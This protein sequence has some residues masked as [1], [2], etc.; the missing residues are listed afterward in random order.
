MLG[1][2]SEGVFYVSA[3]AQ[4]KDL[5]ARMWKQVM[6]RL[7]LGSAHDENQIGFGAHRACHLHRAMHRNVE[8]TL[9]QQCGDVFRGWLTH[10]GGNTGG[11]HDDAGQPAA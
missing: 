10:R 9:R 4:K 2:L 8:A 11:A 6:S 7:H 3:F 1:T 5:A